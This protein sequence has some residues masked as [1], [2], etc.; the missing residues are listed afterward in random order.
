MWAG[1]GRVEMQQAFM[2]SL[3]QLANRWQKDVARRRLE[4]GN[5]AMIVAYHREQDA[6]E[7]LALLQKLDADHEYLTVEQY[8]EHRGVSE[9]TVRRWLRKRQLPDALPSGRSYRIHRNAK[10]LTRRKTDVPAD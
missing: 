10:P 4:P 2:A 9:E 3:T 6:T 5:D 7:L 8:A 1:T